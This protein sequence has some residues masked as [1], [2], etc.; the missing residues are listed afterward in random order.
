MRKDMREDE[1]VRQALDRARAYLQ[2]RGL[3]DPQGHG[4][5]EDEVETA[6]RILVCEGLI[7]ENDEVSTTVQMRQALA[8]WSTH[9]PPLANEQPLDYP[10]IP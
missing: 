1:R 9:Q 10:V 4:F 5:A 3:R 6:Y 8:K 2:W 7:A